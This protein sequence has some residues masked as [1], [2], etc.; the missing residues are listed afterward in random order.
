MRVLHVI[1][2]VSNAHG[3]PSRALALMEQNLSVAGVHVTTVTTDDDGP[4][5]RLTN[6]ARPAE[7]HG[8][9]R[10]YLRKWIDFYKVAPALLPWLQRHLREFDV[11]HI[12]ALFSFSSVVAALMARQK[13]VPYVIRPLGTLTKYGMKRRRPLAKRLSLALFER[14]ILSHA[15]AVHFTSEI[16]LE[17][18]MALDIPLSGVVIPLGVGPVCAEPFPDLF[19]E[20]PSLEGRTVLVY[21]SRLDPKKNVE[22]LLRA[23]AALKPTERRLA[24]LIAG[25][26]EPPY[27]ASLK[28]LARTLNVA[29]EIIW[30]GHIEGCVKAAALGTADIFVLPSLSENFGI[31]AVEAMQAG[32]PCVLGQGVAIAEKARDAGASLTVDS[33]PDS[34]AHALAELLRDK[35][36]RGAM[37]KQAVKFARAAY[38]VDAMA[39]R[40][41]EL[42]GR[43]ASMRSRDAL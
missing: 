37:G 22:G 26:G 4:G 35:P 5:Y 7:A 43:I 12:H 29:G 34:I 11:V 41:T 28:S 14:R 3:G 36:K 15:A 39:D 42:Y 9:R 27:I 2:S 25:S 13:D 18:A 38:S 40:L 10:V 30:L 8:A 1:P 31:A 33:E 6:A 32:L 17:E 24:L 19:R 20:Y 23:F 21:L 16:E